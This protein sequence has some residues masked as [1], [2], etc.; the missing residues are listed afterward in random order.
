MGHTDYAGDRDLGVSP[1]K[2]KRKTRNENTC[3]DVL[4]RER[5]NISANSAMKVVSQKKPVPYCS[6]T[7]RITGYDLTTIPVIS[8]ELNC[9]INLFVNG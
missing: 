6:F 8:V 9:L 2:K 1:V 3:L 7:K 4:Y 5:P